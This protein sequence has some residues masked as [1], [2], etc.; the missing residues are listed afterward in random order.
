[1]CSQVA[2]RYVHFFSLSGEG[3]LVYIGIVDV[4][5]L[6][7]EQPMILEQSGHPVSYPRAYNAMQ[8][9]GA[10]LSNTGF[11]ESVTP[12]PKTRGGEYV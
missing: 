11:S 10:Y 8:F 12:H 3:K 1:M 9:G 6:S 2:L 7:S 4:L 5:A